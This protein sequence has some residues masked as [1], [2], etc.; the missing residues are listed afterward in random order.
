MIVP[1]GYAVSEACMIIID[2]TTLVKTTVSEACMII[3]YSTTLVKTK[4]DCYQYVIVTHTIQHDAITSDVRGLFK[5]VEVLLWEVPLVM[6]LSLEID[7]MKSPSIFG[8][9]RETEMGSGHFPVEGFGKACYFRNLEIVGS[10]NFQP[11][12]S[13]KTNVDSNYYDVNYLDTDDEWGV[14]FF[15]GRP[16]F[17]YTHSSLGN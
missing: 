7:N 17:S 3:I 12:Q 4:I 16:G 5:R 15:Y 11:V 8:R 1:F 2:S 9:D 14:H 10:N 6:F 13:L